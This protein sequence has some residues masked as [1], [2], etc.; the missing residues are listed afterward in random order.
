M[1]K[2]L[3]LLS[4]AP[5]SV[6]GQDISVT[7]TMTNEIDGDI[8]FVIYLSAKATS[9]FTIS[10][11]SHDSTA[12]SD[13]DYTPVSGTLDFAIGDSAK[14]VTVAMVEDSVDEDDEY[15]KLVL[16]DLPSGSHDTLAVG[17]LVNDDYS[18]VAQDDLFY[19]TNEDETLVTMISEVDGLLINDSDENEG[20]LDAVSVV[21][22]SLPNHGNIEIS[23]NRADR[24]GFFYF[25]EEHYHGLDTFYYRAFDGKNYSDTAMAVIMI[26]SVN[27][28]PVLTGIPDQ[29]TCVNQPLSIHLTPFISDSDHDTSDIGLVE[30]GFVLL[31]SNFGDIV[32]ED[33]F[34]KVPPGEREIEI[35]L[36]PNKSAIITVEI[37]VQDVGF[38]ALIARDTLVITF[39]P[40]PEADFSYVT[41]CQG[42]P[43]QFKN[44]SLVQVGTI[45]RKLNWDFDNDQIPDAGGLEEGHSFP[46]DGKHI[47]TLEA[48]NDLGCSSSKT[49][50]IDVFPKFVPEID[51]DLKGGDSTCIFA[52]EE[53]K[54]YQWF[55]GAALIPASNGGTERVIRVYPGSYRVRVVNEFDCEEMSEPFVVTRSGPTALDDVLGQA[56]ILYP[57]PVTNA[58]Q[59]DFNHHLIGEAEVT[60]FNMQG[61]VIFQKTYSKLGQTLQQTIHTSDWPA[62]AY[63]MLLAL[64]GKMGL[65]KLIKE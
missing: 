24:G 42:S 9:P 4:L 64:D 38:G 41:T 50:T 63:Q 58:V 51:I 21:L 53:G 3:I 11:A 22:A 46:T 57:N 59:L 55:K 6:W 30:N 52:V 37:Q 40:Y 33:L 62:G 39:N 61:Q 54:S 10:Y 43:V 17:T 31:N 12:V 25:P 19:I 27:D 45:L 36:I 35:S 32:Q 28:S 1:R 49:D 26:T 23:E 5:L 20:G 16:S 48:L 2:L 14:T 47:V 29:E 13:E 8:S 65:K 60:V 34:A 56:I 44:E 18:P 7:D 15:I